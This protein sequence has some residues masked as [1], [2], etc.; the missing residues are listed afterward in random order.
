MAA[1]ILSSGK[2]VHIQECDTG[3]DYTLYDADGSEWDGGQIDDVDL[4]FDDAFSDIIDGYNLCDDTLR[5]KMDD[6][7]FEDYLEKLGL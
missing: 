7:G 4:S 5:I 1:Y 6:E 2:V 3:I